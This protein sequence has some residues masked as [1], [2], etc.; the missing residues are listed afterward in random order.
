M[1]RRLTFAF[2]IL[3]SAFACAP[4]LAPQAATVP[5]QAQAPPP[6][7]STI[8]IPIHASLA[9]LLPELEKQIPKTLASPSY[10]FDSQHRFAAKYQ[11]VRDPISINMIGAG[12]HVSATVHYALEGCPVLNGAIRNACISCGFGEPMRDVVIALHS[13]LDWSETWSIRPHTAAQ[14]LEFRN[15][16]TVTFLGIDITD[17]KLRPILEEQLAAA[18]TLIDASAPKLASIKPQAQQIWTALQQP[19]PIAANTWLV[20]E[21]SDVA[22]APIRGAGLNVTSAIELRARTRVVVGPKPAVSQK[23]L[24]P[25]RVATAANEGLRV[26]FDVEL[27]YDEASRIITEQFG[28]QKY[29]LGGGATLA[30][31]AI[32]LSAGKNGKTNIEA[33][34]D[35]RGGAFKKYNGLVYLEGVPSFDPASGSVV[36]TDVDYS[37]DP[38]RHNPFLRAANRLAH[39]SVRAQLRSGAK[40]PVGASIATMKGEIERGMTRKLASNV[41]LRGHVDSIEPVSVTVRPEGFT[42]RAVAVG[43]A[44]VELK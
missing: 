37:I 24:P 26:P 15:R 34:I 6:E 3:H 9:P 39:D 18:T 25:L 7:L 41:L 32:R 8:T 22:L 30:I 11:L 4:A 36:V 27:P 43:S 35:Y 42:I 19:N 44:A 38:K 31:D 21:P 10:Q 5:A 16:C 20:L 14:P 28:K 12:L 17:W 33:A 1:K 23:P 13:R 2:C 29:N 40:W